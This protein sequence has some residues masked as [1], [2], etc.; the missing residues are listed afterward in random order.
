MNKWNKKGH[1]H[2]YWEFKYSNGKP[3]YKYTLNNGMRIGYVEWCYK[4]NGKIDCKVI[5]I[6]K[7]QSTRVRY[8]I[9][10]FSFLLCTALACCDAVILY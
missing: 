5:N 3:W 10:F 2:G 1:R 9:V 7:L 4:N 8:G 6:R